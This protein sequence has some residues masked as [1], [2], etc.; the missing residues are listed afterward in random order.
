MLF[1]V[2]A[3]N[4]KNLKLDNKGTGGWGGGGRG[5]SCLY[6]MAAHPKLVPIALC[7]CHSSCST[8]T[9]QLL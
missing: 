7:V 3:K 8:L 5:G 6:V 9:L 2:D 1:A 4:K